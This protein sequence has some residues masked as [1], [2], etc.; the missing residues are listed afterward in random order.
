MQMILISS[1]ADLPS[2]PNP[3]RYNSRLTA[4]DLRGKYTSILEVSDDQAHA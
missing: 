3:Y 4:S 1:K 2:V